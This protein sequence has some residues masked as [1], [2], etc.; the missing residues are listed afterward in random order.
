MMEQATCFLGRGAAYR[1]L[2]AFPDGLP[3]DFAIERYVGSLFQRKDAAYG[4][5]A[6]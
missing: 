4:V 6:Q 2:S 1:G 3:R 5:Q